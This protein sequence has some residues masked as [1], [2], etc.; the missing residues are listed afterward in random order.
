MTTQVVIVIVVVWVMGVVFNLWIFPNYPITEGK[1]VSRKTEFLLCLL[2][3]F[4]PIMLWSA[5]MKGMHPE[6]NEE[7]NLEEYLSYFEEG[8]RNE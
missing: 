2:S 4:L 1:R 7:H 5:W 3:W 8:G 6:D